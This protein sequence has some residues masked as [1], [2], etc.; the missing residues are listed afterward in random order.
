ME[1][2]LKR[3]A[4]RCGWLLGRLRCRRPRHLSSRGR[5]S[6][7][8]PAGGWPLAGLRTGKASWSPWRQGAGCLSSTCLALVAGPARAAVGMRPGLQSS[9]VAVAGSW[10]PL[11]VASP[12]PPPALGLNPVCSIETYGGGVREVRSH[13]S[14]VSRWLTPIHSLGLSLCS[15]EARALV[16]GFRTV[17]SGGWAVKKWGP[18]SDRPPGN[19]L[20]AT[21]AQGECDRSQGTW[22]GSHRPSLEVNVLV[23]CLYLG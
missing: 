15:P 13:R 3:P 2:A 8:G 9:F 22:G 6:S 17:P 11:H 20:L 4:E 14:W 10:G 18:P 23:A 5:L 16:L 1:R 21:V 19:P 12:P 7:E